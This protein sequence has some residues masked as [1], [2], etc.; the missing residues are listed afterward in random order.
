MEARS[1]PPSTALD[2]DTLATRPTR[3]DGDNSNNNNDDND[4][5][6]N[7]YISR[8]PFHAKQVQLRRTGANTKI[9]KC[10]HARHLEQH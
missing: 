3:Q 5:N 8:V 9:K 7:D 10:M 6:S 2:A 1:D 4:N